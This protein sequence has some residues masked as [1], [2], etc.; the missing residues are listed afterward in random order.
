MK[1]FQGNLYTEK[2]LRRNEAIK[3]WATVIVVA[4]VFFGMMVVWP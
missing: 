1:Q 2:E 4:L 3:S